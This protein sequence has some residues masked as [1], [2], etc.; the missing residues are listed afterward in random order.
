MTKQGKN[1][2][3]KRCGKVF[4]LYP[5]LFGKRFYCSKKCANVS[6]ASTLSKNRL[7]DNN[8]AAKPNAKWRYRKDYVDWRNHIIKR[9]KVCQVCSSKKALI[10]HHIKSYKDFPK[11][12]IDINN[13]VTL[14]RS[15]HNKHD[16]G[17]I[18]TQF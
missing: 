11:L 1:T 12:R 6:N 9:D 15:C 14:C 16:A 17:I 18:A 10:A 2:E 5:Y 3:C 8:P 4:Y 13:G 7:G